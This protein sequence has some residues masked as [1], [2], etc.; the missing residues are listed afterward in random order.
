MGAMSW[1]GKGAL[2]RNRALVFVAFVSI[3]SGLLLAFRVRRLRWDTTSEEEINLLDG[4]QGAYGSS[5][6]PPLYPELAAAELSLPQHDENL[7]F[8]EGKD[9]RFLRFGNQMSAVGLNNQLWEACVSLKHIAVCKAL[10]NPF[11]AAC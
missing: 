3:V 10:S 8:P 6:L 11:L 1:M 2:G 4:V 7:P 9:G 5:M